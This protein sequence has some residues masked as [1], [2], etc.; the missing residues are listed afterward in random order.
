VHP[1]VRSQF[2]SQEKDQ[3]YEVSMLVGERPQNWL[4][5]KFEG[6]PIQFGGKIIGSLHQISAY[7][8]PVVG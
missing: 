7:C 1:D 2:Q 6:I 4:T 8:L 3:L 5:G